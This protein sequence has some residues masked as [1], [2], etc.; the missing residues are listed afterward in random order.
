MNA[1]RGLGNT[2]AGLVKKIVSIA[3][4][5]PKAP[6]CWIAIAGICTLLAIYSIGWGVYVHLDCMYYEDL[7]NRVGSAIA[8]YWNAF[9]YFFIALVGV[10]FVIFIKFVPPPGSKKSVER[11]PDRKP[12]IGGITPFISPADNEFD[13]YLQ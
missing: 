9:V 7:Q 13:T 5:S 8:F 12:L 11:D 4:L 6:A 1:V 3:Y 2:G 10:G